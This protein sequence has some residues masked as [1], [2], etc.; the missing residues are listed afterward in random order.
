MRKKFIFW[1]VLICFVAS[2]C[3]NARML[4]IRN[5]KTLT[6]G[7]N[8]GG[9]IFSLVVGGPMQFRPQSV[10]VQDVNQYITFKEKP[11]QPTP[12]A[13]NF[14][15]G[16]YLYGVKLP[17]G[18]YRLSHFDG[19]LGGMFAKYSLLPCNRLFDV[20]EGKI[21]YVGRVD[22]TVYTGSSTTTLK[23]EFF[24]EDLTLFRNTYP[25]LQDREIV[26]ETLY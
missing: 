13:G 25:A 6:L 24:Q 20:A 7:P 21:T 11:I 12:L 23:E 10:Y 14:S 2:G 1:I 18:T 16:V 4:L 9:V 22:A 8:Q 3:G 5:R 19:L 26:R 15:S 17:R